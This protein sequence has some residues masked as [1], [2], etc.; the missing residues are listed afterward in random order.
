MSSDIMIDYEDNGT[1]NGEDSLYH[2]HYQN[3]TGNH[4]NIN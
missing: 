4:W 2:K 1:Q 3:K